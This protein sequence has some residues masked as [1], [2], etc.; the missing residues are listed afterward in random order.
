MTTVGPIYPADVTGDGN[1]V[2]TVSYSNAGATIVCG[3]SNPLVFL[4]TWWLDGQLD[5]P[6]GTVIDS[7]IFTFFVSAA[8][9]AP[10]L[11]FD[12]VDAD[13]FAIFSGS[14]LPSAAALTGNAVSYTAT[15][16]GERTVDITT[17]VQALID[18][19]GWAANQAI[20]II[21]GDSKG[22]GINTLTI[23]GWATADATR[24]ADVAFLTV[25][26]TPAVSGPTIKQ[27]GS[28]Y[29]AASYFGLVTPPSGW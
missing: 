26:Y 9:G 23:H 1:E 27:K 7:A 20:G 13:D 11:N 4:G 14:N 19:P 6:Q 29:M 10:E 22:T 21:A 24:P 25:E 12:V 5:I 3:F 15:D 18:R 28:G 17:A 2:V 16:L 8:N